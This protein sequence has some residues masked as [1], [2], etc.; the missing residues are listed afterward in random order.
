MLSDLRESGAIEQ[1]ADMVLFPYRDIPATDQDK[2][3]QRGPG[4]IIVAKNRDG[5]IG[6]AN[7]EWIPELMTFLAPT[8]MNAAEPSDWQNR[9]IE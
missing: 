2:R 8:D 9:K 3:N 6:A 1:D 7:I 4:Q 5:R